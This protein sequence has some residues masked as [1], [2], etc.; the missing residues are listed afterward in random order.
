MLIDFIEK[1]F[2][3]YNR[4]ARLTPALFAGMPIALIAL[5]L[6][7]DKVWSWGG[8]ISLL[9]W[10]GVLRL[11][12]QLA[13]D[14]GKAKEDELYTAWGGK[15]TTCLLRHRNAQNKV[16]LARWHSKLHDLTGQPLPS[17]SE[18]L[19][20]P[21]LADQAYDTCV[22]FL[23]AKTRDHSKF[24]LLYEENCNYGFRRNLLGVRPLGIITSSFGALFLGTQCAFSIGLFG[25]FTE[26]QAGR[27]ILIQKS[28]HFSNCPPMTLVYLS[29]DLIL[30]IAWL[31]W[32]NSSWVKSAAD[33]YAARLFE[34]CENLP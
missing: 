1:N 5:T 6:F 7:P 25:I 24:S 18:E 17:Q 8:V 26:W 4:K 12:A 9:A 22:R 2:D 3:D 29:I 11:L 13:R 20:D 28:L 16:E 33:V 31:L 21:H 34:S 14:M 32:I 27:P 15:P 23:I 19:A 30:L 10:F